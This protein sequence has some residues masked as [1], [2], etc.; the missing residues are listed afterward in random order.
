MQEII[1]GSGHNSAIDWWALGILVYEMLYGRT[2][3]LDK[4]RNGTFS[5]I[6]KK[7]VTFPR[8]IPVSIVAKQFIHALLQKDPTERL[9]SLAG[10]D[11][12]KKH[13]FFSSIMWPL[14]RCMN[15]PLLQAP[16]ITISAKDVG[17]LS[18][19]THIEWNDLESTSTFIPEF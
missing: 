6:L 3:F 5:N 19:G 12:I 14:V 4:S 7:E 18:E 9:G 15:P 17:S 8:N 11:D 16:S 13:P 2:P 10:A 1:T